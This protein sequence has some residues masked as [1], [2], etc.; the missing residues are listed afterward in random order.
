MYAKNNGA[1]AMKKA[2]NIEN[3]HIVIARHQPPEFFT[4]IPYSTTG[5]LPS[6]LNF[7]GNSE[8]SSF[9]NGAESSYGNIIKQNLNSR[10]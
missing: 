7:T 5:F 2:Q 10:S 4:Y 6:A 3:M 9:F 1:M 8:F